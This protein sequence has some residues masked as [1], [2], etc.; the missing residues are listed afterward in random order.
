[1][2][3]AG[4]RAATGPAAPGVPARGLRHCAPKRQRRQ[5][6][7]G[8]PTGSRPLLRVC[9]SL[10]STTASPVWTCRRAA[11]STSDTPPPPRLSLAPGEQSLEPWERLVARSATNIPATP[12]GRPLA[13]DFRHENLTPASDVAILLPRDRAVLFVALES[14]ACLRGSGDADFR[15][16]CTMRQDAGGCL[17]E[18]SRCT[19]CCH[20]RRPSCR[21]GTPPTSAGQ[22]VVSSGAQRKGGRPCRAEAVSAYSCVQVV[23]GPAG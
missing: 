14:G 17:R 23:H 3:P 21:D 12:F 1:M 2:R 5:S 6:L 22:F 8:I 11:L 4:W 13:V 10:P 19:D 9:T 7:P 15:C 20:P 16:L 18:R